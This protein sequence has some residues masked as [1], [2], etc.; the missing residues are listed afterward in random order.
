MRVYSGAALV[1]KVLFSASC[2]GSLAALLSLLG[3]PQQAR[4]EEAC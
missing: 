1:N 3:E 2:A 4:T